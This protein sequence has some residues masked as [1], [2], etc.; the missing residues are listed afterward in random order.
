M[1]KPILVP[2]RLRK[3]LKSWREAYF[4]VLLFD[5]KEERLPEILKKGH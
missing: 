1:Q 5:F 3:F 2:K 4:R